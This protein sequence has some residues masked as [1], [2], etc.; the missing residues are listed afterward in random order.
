M[1]HLGI[2]ATKKLNL[3]QFE[4]KA[5]NQK[6]VDKEYCTCGDYLKHNICMNTLDTFFAKRDELLKQRD[7]Y[8]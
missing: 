3:I 1:K 2:Q 7:S 5:I 6:I 4:I 8:I